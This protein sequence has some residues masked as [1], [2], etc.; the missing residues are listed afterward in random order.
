[1]A[2]GLGGAGRPRGELLVGQPAHGHRARL[3]EAAAR[4]GDQGRD[5]R[6]SDMSPERLAYSDA[7]SASALV[8]ALCRDL[9]VG[10][11]NFDV[12]VDDEMLHFF[13]FTEGY[14]FE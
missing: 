13:L 5:W 6:S 11:V 9:V 14:P 1:S 2:H 10:G 3:D 12:H 7:E 8:Q 4:V